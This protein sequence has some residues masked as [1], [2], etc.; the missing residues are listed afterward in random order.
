M[1]GTLKKKRMNEILAEGSYPERIKKKWAQGETVNYSAFQTLSR[2]TWM[3]I[4][5]EFCSASTPS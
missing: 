4:V 5:R 3:G 1:R 2:N